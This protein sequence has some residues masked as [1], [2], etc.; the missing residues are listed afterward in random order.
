MLDHCRDRESIA[1][2]Y[3]IDDNWLTVGSDWPDPYASIFSPG[4]PQ[5]EIFLSCLREC[6]AVLVYNDVLADDV[7]PYVQRLIQL[8]T[9]VRQADFAAPLRHRELLPQIESLREWRE[10]TGGTIAGY[11]G[12]QRFSEGAFRAL[13]APAIQQRRQSIKIVLFGVVSEQ[14]RQLF[15]G[16]AISL[17]YVELRPLCR[18][19]RGLAPDILV[20]PLDDSRTSRSKCPNKYLEYSIAGAAGVYSNVPPYAG[21]VVDGRTGLLVGDR[22]SGVLWTCAAMVRLADDAHA[23]NSR[24]PRPPAQDVLGAL[25]ARA[26]G[27]SR[28]RPS[29]A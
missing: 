14:Q 3:M 6:D 23:A 24:S 19:R 16:R 1:T 29:R 10:Q 7:R 21:T 18:R 4:L 9:N 25:R 15:G 22:R 2:L 8:Q 26:F 20:A 27:S 5:Y 17:P 28:L 13:A 12:S 11:I